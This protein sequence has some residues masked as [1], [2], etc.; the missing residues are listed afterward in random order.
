MIEIE[1]KRVFLSGPMTGCKYNN[2]AEFARAHAIVKLAGATSVYN[3]AHQWLME[4]AD[5]A[6]GKRHEDYMLDCVN[7][8]TRR[9]YDGKPYYHLLVSLPNWWMSEGAEHERDVAEHCGIECVDLDAIEADLVASWCEGLRE[10]KQRSAGDGQKQ[11]ADTG[12][13]L[14]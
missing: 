6:E 8:L 7:E 3:P 14:A 13:G 11:R 4:R 12:Q 1:H 2:V 9:N 5:A 10:E